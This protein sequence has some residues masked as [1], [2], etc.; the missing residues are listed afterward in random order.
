MAATS[1]MALP[2]LAAGQAQKE[3]THNEALQLP[4]MAVQTVVQGAPLA[5]PPVAPAAD[6]VYLVA[7]GATGEFAGHDGAMATWSAG[8]WR[9]PSTASGISLRR[10]GWHV[11]LAVR[12]IGVA[13]DGRGNRSRNVGDRRPEWRLYGRCRSA[14][15]DHRNSRAFARAAPHRLIQFSHAKRGGCI[16]LRDPMMH[17][18]NNAP[19]R[20]LPALGGNHIVAPAISFGMRL[21]KGDFH[22]AEASH[23]GGPRFVDA[24][25][26]CACARQG[27]V[28]RPR[29]RRHEG[30][31]SRA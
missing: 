2:L 4:D 12:R 9:F 28:R 20:R 5:A 17:Y 19:R 30:R 1:R 8:G 26:A 7:A 18:C 16:A 14:R 10:G 24:G 27:V 3:I 23:F 31:R 6:A 22:Y 21:L 29:R 13:I 25:Y 15:V 11:G